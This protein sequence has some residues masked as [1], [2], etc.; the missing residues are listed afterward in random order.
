MILSIF[1]VENHNYNFLKMR[2]REKIKHN[3]IM[4]YLYIKKIVQY[5][6]N[7]LRLSGHIEGLNVVLIST[8]APLNGMEN[9]LFI[10]VFFSKLFFFNIIIIN[11]ENDKR[12]SIFS[13][14]NF[15]FIFKN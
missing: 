2:K 7:N 10:F 5:F 11:D 3:N 13:C 14:I 15:H 9:Y 6:K 4:K 8:F 1:K 12:I